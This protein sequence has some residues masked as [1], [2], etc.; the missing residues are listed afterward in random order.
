MKEQLKSKQEDATCEC[1][2]NFC[3]HGNKMC[4]GPLDEEAKAQ[5][6]VERKVKKDAKGICR[7][8]WEKGNEYGRLSVASSSGKLPPHSR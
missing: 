7:K 6:M 4:G 2:Q 3:E 5:L 8:C 1:E